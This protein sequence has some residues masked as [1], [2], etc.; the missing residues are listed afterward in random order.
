MYSIYYSFLYR[1]IRFD[2]KLS[3][4]ITFISD[5]SNFR[6]NILGDIFMNLVDKYL[7]ESKIKWS[8]SK[9]RQFS[10]AQNI[11]QDKYHIQVKWGDDFEWR[12]FGYDEKTVSVNKELSSGKAKTR[13]EAMKQAEDAWKKLKKI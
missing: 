3:D 10:K 8:H 2:N 6:E 1:I 4:L 13:K 11:D 5:L 9:Y 12:I 7:G